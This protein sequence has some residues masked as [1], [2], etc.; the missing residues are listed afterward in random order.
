M[1]EVTFRGLTFEPYI[2]REEIDKQ[3]QRLADEIRCDCR[4]SGDDAPMFICVLTGAFMFATD[5]FRACEIPKSEIAFIRFKSY[6][7]T[8]STGV[9]NEVMGLTQDIAGRSVYIIED[10]VDT[11]MT[12]KQLREKLAKENPK[13]VKM[14]S[15]LFKPDSLIV[16][17]KPEFVGFEN[18]SKFILGYGLDID[19][20][21][22]YLNDIYVLKKDDK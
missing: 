4:E 7:G 17:T 11:G 10:I 16:G 19:E 6:E 13:S 5:L 21:A 8:S 14:V 22:R 12:A 15:L 18:P 1:K 2:T 9:I 3:I 20:Q